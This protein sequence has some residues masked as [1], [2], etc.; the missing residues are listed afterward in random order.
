MTEKTV[1]GTTAAAGNDLLLPAFVRRK[2]TGIHINLASLDSSE[3]FRTFADRIFSSGQFLRNLDYANLHKLLYES[4][5]ETLAQER[6]K[7]E[8]A[9][10]TLELYLASAIEDLPE[11]RIPL[12][13]GFKLDPQGASAEYFFEPLVI[14]VEIEEPVQGTSAT[15][16]TATG[17]RKR[18]ITQVTKLDFDE[19]VAAAWNKGLR[20]GLD[21]ALIKAGIQ[22]NQ[23][24]RIVIA[25]MLP[26]KPGKDASINEQ[27][28]ALHRSD[29]PKIRSDGRIDLCTFSNRFPQVKQ[30]GKLMKKIPRVLG[31]AG[32]NIEGKPVEAELPKDFDIAALAG[33]GTRI[34]SGKDGDYLVATLDGFL[35]IDT[36]TNQLSVTEKIINMEG[37]SLRTTGN[38]NFQCDEYEEHGEV[39]EQREVKGK[40]MTFMNNVFGNL[41]SEGGRIVVKSNLSGGSAKSPGGSIAIEGKASRAVIEA[42]SGEVALNY[43]DSSIVIGKKVH[44]KH[45]VACEI[46]ADDIRIEVAEGCALL[47]RH[48]QVGVCKDK[49]GVENLVS[50]LVPDPATLEHEMDMI[51]EEKA[52]ISTNIEGKNQEYQL[53]MEDR[54][55]K[56][57]LGIQKKLKTGEI[58]LTPEQKA[59]LQHLQGK[60][61]KP[62]QLLQVAREKI[63]A[64]LRQIDELD[65]RIEQLKR[66]YAS[67][68]AGIACVLANIE[69]ETMVRSIPAGTDSHALE[70]LAPAQFRSKLREPGVGTKLF[71]N[72]CGSFEWRLKTESE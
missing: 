31:K 21:V 70:N 20:Y 3:A 71:A 69:G 7:L 15:D 14:D 67:L 5:A 8:Q 58:T 11:S 54:N 50:I 46:Y 6:R 49:R 45:A 4:D 25:K 56:M 29:A 22:K 42:K 62:L 37:V 47:G 59:N 17:S 57:F 33:P 9:G 30:G 38:V 41:I 28:E 43:V 35:N 48:V 36:A 65:N 72:D 52:A 40:H 60:I 13:R 10:K 68:S 1:T 51:A 64:S 16:D 39:Q 55:L 61:A 18:E 23:P 32:W 12:Y 66:D 27:T 63:A 24:E 26:P 2:D 44:I 53:L 19:F 34:E